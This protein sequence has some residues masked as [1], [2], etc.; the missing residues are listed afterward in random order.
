[1]E[2]GLRMQGKAAQLA[3]ASFPDL[4]QEDRL[5]ALVQR[6]RGR[7]TTLPELSNVTSAAMAHLHVESLL[8][9]ALG[10][11]TRSGY[12]DWLARKLARPSIQHKGGKARSDKYARVQEAVLTAL[13]DLPPQAGAAAARELMPLAKQVG[14]PLG[15]DVAKDGFEG[16]VLRWIR[17]ANIK[18]RPPK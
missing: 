4:P 12:Q 2:L 11:I 10:D 6:L 17:E 15:I 13:A 8:S 18:N 16:T 5:P 3:D 14:A 9:A 7:Y 1:M